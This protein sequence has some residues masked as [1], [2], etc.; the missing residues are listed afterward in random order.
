MKPLMR[1]LVGLAMLVVLLLGVS[2]ALPSH[3]TVARTVDIN[4]PEA[5]VFPYLNS[6]RKFNEWSPW[7]ARG[8]DM[9]YEFTGPESGKGA[10]MSWKSEE[11]GEGTQ[12]IIESEANKYIKVAL[13]FGDQGG[14]TSYYRLAPRG[15]GTRVTW[16]FDTEIGNNPIMRWMG[17][18]FDRWIGTDYEQGLARLKQVVEQD[19]AG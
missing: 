6:P 18:M 5:E 15:A 14:G 10:G 19:G 16:G 2:Y 1:L 11:F 9:V 7:A 12:E 4:A 8:K 17:L 13:D 3:I